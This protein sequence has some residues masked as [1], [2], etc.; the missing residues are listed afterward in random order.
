MNPEKELTIVIPAWNEEKNLD[1]LLPLLNKTLADLGLRGEIIVADH[2]AKD[3]TGDICRREGSSLLK[4]SRA[5]YGRALTEAFAAARGEFVITMD[6]DLSHPSAFIEVLWENRREA[7]VLIASRYVEGGSA[8]MTLMRRFLSRTV[9]WV[10]SRAL[11]VPAADLSS[12]FRLYRKAV[13][14]DMQIAGRDFNVLQEILI[15]ALTRVY[16]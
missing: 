2:E 16:W 15:R 13:L 9:N 6:A 5:G 3:S 4:V 14:D 11:S 10:F 7:D 12:G 1:L 8:D